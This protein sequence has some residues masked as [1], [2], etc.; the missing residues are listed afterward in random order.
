MERVFISVHSHPI[1]CTRVWRADGS[2]RL[3]VRQRLGGA[4]SDMS[5]LEY[6]MRSCIVLLFFAGNSER[7]DGQ[8]RTSA[9]SSGLRPPRGRRPQA[10]PGGS[11]SHGGHHRYASTK[12]RPQPPTR[13]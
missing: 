7:S 8:Q 4:A 11:S 9:A 2:L 10:L 3:V 12:A 13:E 6:A 1:C 5:T